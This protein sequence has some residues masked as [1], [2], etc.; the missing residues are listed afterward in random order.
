MDLRIVVLS[1]DHKFVSWDSRWPP[2]AARPVSSSEA[3]LHSFAELWGPS[4]MITKQI[5]LSSKLYHRAVFLRAHRQ[6]GKRN[7]YYH[8]T[9]EESS[10]EDSPGPT[11]LY[12]FVSDPTP[13]LHGHIDSKILHFFCFSGSQKTALVCHELTVN[14]GSMLAL[15]AQL[16]GQRIP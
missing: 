15:S 10:S 9:T 3:S 4:A 8:G 12:D 6:G 14:T 5:T 16:L 11:Y 13:D 2:G 1:H 7:N